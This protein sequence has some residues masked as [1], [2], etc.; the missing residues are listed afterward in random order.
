MSKILVFGSI[1]VDYVAPVNRLPGPGETIKTDSYDALPGGKGANQALAAAR[2]GAKT[3]MIGAIGSDGLEGV[4]LSQL[5]IAGVDTVGVKTYPG[6]S[7]LAMIAVDEKGENQIVVVSGANASARANQ[8]TELETATCLVTQN[9]VEWAQTALAHSMAKQA[10]VRVLHNAA[11]AHEITAEE[12]TCIDVLIVNEHEL[13]LAAKMAH[14]ASDDEKAEGLLSKGVS[15]VVLTLGAKGAK[16][17]EKGKEPV[18]V[19]AVPTQVVDT[20][21]AGDAFVG[22]LAAALAS[23]VSLE[24]SIARANAYAARVCGVMGAQTAPID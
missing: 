12:L 14:H 10:G 8:L 19:A 13:T 9:E 23:A 17:Y 11:P 4:S 21:G 6:A 7:G 24:T 3:A 22:A 5:L 20:T 18:S 1:N 16:L 2:N 15:A